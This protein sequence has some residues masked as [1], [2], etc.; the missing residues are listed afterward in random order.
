MR[1]FE[2][3]FDI[4]QFN[5]SRLCCQIKHSNIL[6]RLM[7]FVS[8]APSYHST[9]YLGGDFGLSTLP[10]TSPKQTLLLKNEHNVPVSSNLHIAKIAAAIRKKILTTLLC[11]RLTCLSHD[12]SS[13]S[14][15][16]RQKA[17]SGC[18]PH[19]RTPRQHLKPIPSKSCI[20]I[21]C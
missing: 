11:F 4:T 3:D 10:Q 2:T 7:N 21:T 9:L 17:E 8:G 13:S 15:I 20:I 1:H 16:A 5:S 19:S 18:K 12:N 6:A 14:Y